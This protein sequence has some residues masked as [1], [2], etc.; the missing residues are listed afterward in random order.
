MASFFLRAASRSTISSGITSSSNRLRPGLKTI[1]CR[2]FS[3]A[4]IPGVGK[5][6]TSTG[7]VGL[8]VDHDALSKIV[9][10]YTALLEKA[11]EMPPTA[12]YRIN[13]E[14]L[15]RYRINAAT[16]FPDDPEMVE[17]L[18]NCGQVEELVQQADEE[19]AVMEMYLRNK[20]WELVGEVEIEYEPSGQEDGGHGDV[21]WDG[22]A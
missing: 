22:K 2:M 15:A 5:G 13:I 18:C 6:K 21:E 19:M 3:E 10:K 14:K 20:W 17:E 4:V 11:Q 12:Q 1:Q 7:L 8:K 16:Q 9:T